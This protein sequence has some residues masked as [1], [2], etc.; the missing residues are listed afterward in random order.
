MQAEASVEVLADQELFYARPSVSAPALFLA[1]ASTV[2]S[3]QAGSWQPAQQLD[4]LLEL[5][6]ALQ[7]TPATSSQACLRQQSSDPHLKGLSSYVRRCVPSAHHAVASSTCL[8]LGNRPHMLSDLL[9]IL[10]P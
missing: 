5:E 4:C 7:V 1:L 10:H 8:C 9:D 3:M 6:A 2:S